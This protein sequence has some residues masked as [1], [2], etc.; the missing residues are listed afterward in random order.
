M[1]T[2]S[3][4]GQPRP[5]VEQPGLASG[6][7]TGRWWSPALL[8]SFSS[9]GHGLR[10]GALDAPASHFPG[11][12]A[13]PGSQTAP[14]SKPEKA[15][16]STQLPA[17]KEKTNLAAYVPLLTQGWAEILVRRPTGTPGGG[18]ALSWPGPLSAP[19]VGQLH[20]GSGHTGASG[21]QTGPQEQFRGDF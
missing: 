14:P 2:S 1:G 20:K 10:V 12:P 11:S 16:A 19:S 13:S 3:G 5:Q 17:Q 7:S 8:L 21:R 9:G 18:P 15:S 4:L 6:F